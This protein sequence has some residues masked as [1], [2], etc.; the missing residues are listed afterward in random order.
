MPKRTDLFSGKALK[1]LRSPEALDTTL[2]I[3]R[4]INWAGLAVLGGIIVV[5]IVWGIFGSVPVRVQGLGVILDSGSTVYDVTAP[6]PGRVSA[7]EVDVGETMEKG[8]LIAVLSLPTLETERDNAQRKLE[9]LREQYRRQSEFAAVDLLRRRENTAAAIATLE[10]KIRGNKEHLT[11]LR[12]LYKTLQE[13]LQKG[14]VT[15]QQVEEAR[16]EIFSTQQSIQDAENQISDSRTAQIEY[17]NEQANA[18]AQLEEQVL[19]AE[20]DLQQ[21]MVSLDTE[22]LIYSPVSGIVTELDVKPGTLVETDAQIAVIEEVGYDLDAIT[23][24][25]IGKG[26]TI[27]PGMQARVSPGAVE[28]DLYGSI[29]GKVVS[30]SELPE[31]RDGLM[32]VLGNAALVDEMMAAGAPIRVAIHLEKDPNTVSGLRWSSSKG[33]PQKITP[34]DTASAAVTLRSKKPIDLV[35]PIFEAWVSSD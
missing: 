21:I 14:Y 17:E 19:A 11:F 25:E 26:K 13:E 5:L 10:A 20:S 31:T 32:E 3:T 34:G 1:K 27:N 8:Q 28:R 9:T 24:F 22:R 30:V 35:I 12:S 29:R 18:L 23:F 6:A 33:P 7:V 15:R 16:S 2:K 4:P